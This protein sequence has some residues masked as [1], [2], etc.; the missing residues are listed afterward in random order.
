MMLR[1]CQIITTGELLSD[2]NITR[3]F[4]LMLRRQS[5]NTVSTVK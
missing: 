2:I 5:I 3:Q 1:S 4:N